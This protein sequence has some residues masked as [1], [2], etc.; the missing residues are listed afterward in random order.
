MGLPVSVLARGPGARS[1]EAEQAVAAVFAELRQVDAI[2]SPYR[3]DSDVSMLAAGEL[4]LTTTRQEVRDV[5]DRCVELRALTGGLFDPT[6]PQGVWDPSGYVKGWAAQRAIGNLM[7]VAECD[8]C[9]NAGGD[10]VVDCP[11]G[12]PFVVGIQ[13]PLDAQGLAAT[14]SLAAGAVA[15]SGTAARGA[16]LYD[17]RTGGPAR[18]V[19]ASV[20]VTGPDLAVADVL[21]TAAFVAGESWSELLSAATD[22]TGL[23]IGPDGD[24]LTSET[25]PGTLT[26]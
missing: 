26:V 6:T 12:I 7:G 14:L 11:T 21:A 23:A 17:P 20:T 22:Y 5:A 3:V 19:W 16:H 24:L 25:W 13:D 10:V 1:S 8:W 18:G 2:F 15:T 4:A 9:L